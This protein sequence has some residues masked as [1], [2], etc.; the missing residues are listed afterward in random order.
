MAVRIGIDE[1]RFWSLTPGQLA[2]RIS[3]HGWREEQG[4][5]AS[6]WQTSLMLRAWLGKDAPT[7]N[8]L[9]GKVKPKPPEDPYG[10]VLKLIDPQGYREREW[11][12]EHMDS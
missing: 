5:E 10:E 3:A 1:D 2:E 12:K 8:Q 6:T 11:A 9:L 4:L 7:L